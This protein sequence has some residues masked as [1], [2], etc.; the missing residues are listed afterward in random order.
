MS[1]ST[2]PCARALVFSV[3][4]LTS[5]AAFAQSINLTPS[6]SGPE[7]VCVN[8]TGGLT[9][10]DQPCSDPGAQSI[11]GM[12][13]SSGTTATF[14]SG[15][16]VH[17]NGS[18]DFSGTTSFL[19]SPTFQTGFTT[20]TGTS[21]FGSSATFNSSVTVAANQNVNFNGNRLQG[22]GAPTDDTDAANKKYVDDENTAQNLAIG[23][24]QTQIDSIV[25]VNNQQ[26]A[27]LT[28][29]ENVNAS[30]QV[31]ID[32]NAAD[33]FSL[34]SDVRDLQQRDDELAEG[35]AIALA[36]DAP[37]LK[38]GQTFA[39]R[40]GWGNFDGSNAAGV[41]AAGAITQNVVVDAG[42][43]WGTSQ[44]T[45]AGKAGVTVGW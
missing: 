17:L 25:T 14:D 13:F 42:V 44:G 3:V 22:V 36:L 4:W 21:T 30:Q 38:N 41:T 2:F 7:Y 16:S 28:T 11:T 37:L 26:D 5:P 15:S 1:R 40:G 43:G 27:R 35:I 45:V 33:I 29:I 34:Q 6:A 20:L 32:Q 10:N 23:N 39:M 9:R 24:Q 12:T 8:S 18:T 31:Q 19:N